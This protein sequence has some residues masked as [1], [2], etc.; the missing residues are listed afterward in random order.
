MK[1]FRRNF[2]FYRGYTQALFFMTLILYV[3]SF[4]SPDPFWK[5]W[6]DTFLDAVAI[7]SLI[8]GELIRLW[9]VSHA[10]KAT[11]SRR[12]KAQLLVTTGPYAYLRHPIYLGNFLIGLGIVV[13]SGSFIFVPIFLLLFVL[14][15]HAIISEEEGFLR[16][17]F[18]MAFEQYRAR[19][20]KYFPIRIHVGRDLLF[21]RHLPLKELG[22]AC[23][24]LVGG[25]FFEWIES[26]LHRRWIIGFYD[27]LTKGGIL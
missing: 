20:S 8:S 7:F 19:V 13:I 2:F 12:L 17:R 6:M 23:G 5:R 18:G 9:A 27:W 21:G 1:F 15:Y 25:F 3:W 10:G 11:R 16:E 22:T 4:P 26:P 14:Y 24:I